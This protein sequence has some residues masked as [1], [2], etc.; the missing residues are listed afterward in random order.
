VEKPLCR[1]CGRRH[2]LG[3]EPHQFLPLSKSTQP[4]V[5]SQIHQQSVDSIVSL[6]S[7]VARTPQQR[8]RQRNIEKY[9]A[10][11]RDYMKIYRK[12]KRAEK[13]DSPGKAQGEIVNPGANVSEEFRDTR[14]NT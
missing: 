5:P 4:K 3:R 1:F 6:V 9:R 7:P 10:N 14:G 8:W 12:T 13:G 2:Y 11:H